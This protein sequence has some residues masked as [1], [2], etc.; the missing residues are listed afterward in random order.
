MCG[1]GGGGG[2]TKRFWCTSKDEKRLPVKPKAIAFSQNITS[3]VNF[4]LGN[5]HKEV[6]D[7]LRLVNHRLSPQREWI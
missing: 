7:V 1:G 4:F 6:I 5:E 3:P 2:F